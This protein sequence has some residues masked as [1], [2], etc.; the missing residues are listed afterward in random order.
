MQARAAPDHRT[1][2]RRVLMIFGR[3]EETPERDGGEPI[4]ARLRGR[5]VRGRGRKTNLRRSSG[6]RT[7]TP[8]GTCDGLKLKGRREW[9]FPARR[10]GC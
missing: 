6:L 1:P 10:S 4:F 2:L 7:P 5:N 9:P 3:R 8:A